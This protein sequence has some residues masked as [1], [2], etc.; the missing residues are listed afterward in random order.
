MMRK[1]GGL[2]GEKGEERLKLPQGMRKGLGTG[3]AAK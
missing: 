1:A 3:A 2:W